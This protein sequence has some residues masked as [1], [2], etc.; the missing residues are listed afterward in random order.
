MNYLII[1]IRGLHTARNTNIG[2]TGIFYFA[3]RLRQLNVPFRITGS[4]RDSDITNKD[5][6]FLSF[7]LKDHRVILSTLA[8]KVVVGGIG[9]KADNIIVSNSKELLQIRGASSN[10]GIDDL[11]CV[12][13]V[14]K[15]SISNDV[16]IPYIFKKYLGYVKVIHFNNGSG[17]TYKKCLFCSRP[18]L[19]LLSAE[20]TAKAIC[21]IYRKYKRMV[22]LSLDGPPKHYLLSVADNILKVTNKPYPKWGC[23][24]MDYYV[25]NS[26]LK[27]VRKSGCVSVGMGLEYLDNQVL[28]AI[29][30]G[31]TI[32]HYFKTA[33]D[34]MSLDMYGHFCLIDFDSLVPEIN[35]QRHYKNLYKILDMKYPKFS[36]ALS[37]LC[38]NDKL[39]DALTTI[40]PR[41]IRGL[42]KALTGKG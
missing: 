37:K 31:S 33:S 29:Q 14:A 41:T 25:D 5:T 4:L 40:V 22:Q 11:S 20:I 24:V 13:M 1:D 7:M 3:E 28:S 15:P 17:C 30:K 18:K 26:F 27:H 32:E 39:D 6:V 8:R 35:K 19:N 16:E 2:I 42:G 12:G 34:L 36:F 9:A 21:A 23:S 10:V 38:S